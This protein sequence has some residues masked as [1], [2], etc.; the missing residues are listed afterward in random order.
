M[1]KYETDQ[2]FDNKQYVWGVSALAYKYEGFLPRNSHGSVR[3]GFGR[4]EPKED[5]ART[6]ALGGAALDAFNR[7]NLEAYYNYPLGGRLTSVEFQ[8]R[9]FQEVSPPAAVDAAGIDRHR[10]GTIRLNI[11][12]DL[13]VAYSKGS[14]PFDKKSD[15]AVTLGW[16]HK[17]D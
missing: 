6:T 15:R 9:H 13:F 3:V 2:G 14:L 10:L 17:L 8:Y 1:L 4:V 7:W 12:G 11:K 5:A 16:S